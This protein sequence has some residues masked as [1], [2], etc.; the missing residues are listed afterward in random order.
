MFYSN[1]EWKFSQE[2]VSP[3]NVEIEYLKY[4]NVEYM[5]A[6]EILNSYKCTYTNNIYWKSSQIE[7]SLFCDFQLKKMLKKLKEN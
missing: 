5:T 6:Y 4:I 3:Y 7:F 1:V 2:N